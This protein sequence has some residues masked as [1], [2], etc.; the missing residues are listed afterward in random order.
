MATEVKCVVVGD[1]A[2]GKSIFL[3]VVM[4][5]LTTSLKKIK[6]KREV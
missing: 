4:N 3:K 5:L 6:K 2:V 1:G